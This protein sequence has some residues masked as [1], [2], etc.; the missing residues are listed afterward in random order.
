[1]ALKRRLPTQCQE[2]RPSLLFR[3]VK[4]SHLKGHEAHDEYHC[5][6]RIRTLH[7]A[8]MFIFGWTVRHHVA[9]AAGAGRLW[10]AC[11]HLF[12]G[13]LIKAEDPDHRSFSHSLTFVHRTT[14]MLRLLLSISLLV[15]ASVPVK[16]QSEI[17]CTSSDTT[18]ELMTGFVFTSPGEILETRPDTLQLADCIQTCR[19]NSSC[20]ALNF[21]TGLCVLFKSNAI[22]APGKAL[23]PAHLTV[24]FSCNTY[25]VLFMIVAWGGTAASTDSLAIL[26]LKT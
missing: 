19:S 12:Q 3:G 16:S 6:M 9:E 8:L 2:L 1:M 21:E 13:W 5:K 17:E 18:F 20:Q 4:W 10:G 26:S 15:V 22:V 11:I 7:L 25:Y 24:P 23:R 14:T